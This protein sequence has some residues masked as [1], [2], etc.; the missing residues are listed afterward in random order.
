MSPL[1]PLEPRVSI[2]SCRC[3]RAWKKR[4]RGRGDTP[5]KAPT[6]VL[7]KVVLRNA[8]MVRDP[9][10]FH[11]VSAVGGSH[12]VPIRT[13][14]RIAVSGGSGFRSTFPADRQGHSQGARFP[15]LCS[16]VVEHIVDPQQ[17]PGMLRYL[18][19]TGSELLHSANAVI[20]FTHLVCGWRP[21]SSEA[22]DNL[23]Q[24]GPR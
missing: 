12:L 23:H 20:L 9:L 6:K 15:Q 14:A 7:Q 17:M 13:R 24:T 8:E 11:V 3:C 2:V 10:I 5:P 18:S 16:V 22:W 21:W 1:S 19:S 4:T